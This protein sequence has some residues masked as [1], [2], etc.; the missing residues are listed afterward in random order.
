MVAIGSNW[1][2]TCTIGVLSI[3]NEVTKSTGSLE[4]RQVWC[5]TSSE[6]FNM[7]GLEKSLGLGEDL[8][9]IAIDIDGRKQTFLVKQSAA[10]FI[11]ESMFL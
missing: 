8:F 11:S 9:P 4:L 5:V 3:L 6:E 2:P 7:A 10:A 1:L